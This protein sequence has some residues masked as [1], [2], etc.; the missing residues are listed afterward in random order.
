MKE[1]DRTN[2]GGIK[3]HLCTNCGADMVFDPASGKLSCPYCDTKKTISSNLADLT[4]QDLQ[5]FL[6]IG[7]ASL[8]GLIASLQGPGPPTVRARPVGA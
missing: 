4:E 1:P 6:N 3:R 7:A 5:E 2:D 8:Q